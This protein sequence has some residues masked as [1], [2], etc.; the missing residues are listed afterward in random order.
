M[1]EM[2]NL[3]VASCRNGCGKTWFPIRTKGDDHF[4]K[5]C[6]VRSERPKGHFGRV[7]AGPDLGFVPVN[8]TRSLHNFGHAAQA[9]D[10]AGSR[11]QCSTPYALSPSDPDYNAFDHYF[12]L[13]IVRDHTQHRSPSPSSPSGQSPPRSAAASPSAFDGA[14]LASQSTTPHSPPPPPHI[15]DSPRPFEGQAHSGSSTPQD[16]FRVV[17]RRP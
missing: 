2:S 8:T 16:A 15:R 3:R 6:P 13:N 10:L 17:A 4:E 14:I 7:W 9:P 11:Q 12:G 5:Y 1:H